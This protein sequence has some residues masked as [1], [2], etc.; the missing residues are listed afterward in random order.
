MED[1]SR[2]GR[3]VQFRVLGPLEVDAGDGP[4]PLGGPKQRA[5]LAN[6][7]VRANQVV[8][9][10]TL[11]DALW[12]DDSPDKARNT[13]QT[14]VSNL[15]RPLGDSRLQG[16]PPGYVLHLDPIEL[17]ADRFDSLVREA[18]KT[19]PVDPMVAAS[20]LEDALGMWRGP[21][22][23]DLA[24]QPSLLAESARLD[25]L[26]L[27]AQQARC[28]ALLACGDPAR[29][30]GILEALVAEHPL[31]ESLWVLLLLS[32]YRDG[33]Q[34]E[35][36]DAFGR[37]RDLLADE[38]GID[39]SPELARLHE[40]ILRQDPG[41]LP[42]GEPLRGYRLMEK[43][44]EGPTAGVFRG[45]HPQEGRDVAVKVVRE[46][47]ADDPEF[48]RTF[49]A[50]AQIVAS[51]EHPAIVPIHD[52]WREPGRAYV[53]SKYLRGG[54]L[55]SLLD[56][57][58][59][60]EDAW[61][62]SVIERVASAVA[63]AH[64]RGI[65]HGGVHASNILFDTE[66]RAYLAD[67]RLGSNGAGDPSNDDREVAE[68]A[69]VL[70]GDGMPRSIRALVE[71]ANRST[72]PA[73]AAFVE[74]ARGATEPTSAHP[75][76]GARNPYKGLRAFA[77]ADAADFFGRDSLV[78]RLVGA[79]GT[80][81]AG[82]F[83]AI[84][85]PSGSGKS[86]V[87][88][89]G[90]VPAIKRGDRDRYVASMFPGSHPFDE[91]ETAL[92]RVAARPVPRLLETIE[93]GPRGLLEAADLVL[94]PEGELVLVVD[95][96]EE[97]FT[98]TAAGRERE[99]FLEALRVASVD[100][101]SRILVIVTL[102]ADFYDRPLA[103]A[104][105]GDLLAAGTQAIPPLTPDELEQAIRRPAE[106]VGIRTEPGLEAAMIADVTQQ[107]GGLPLV[108]YAL[109]E[110]FERRDDDRLTLAAYEEIG[111]V[112]GALSARAERLYR[113]L[114]PG[115]RD[116]VRQVFLRLVALGEG[117]RDTRRRVERRELHLLDVHE[118]TIDAVLDAY[119]RH[120]LLTFDR[121]PNSRAPTVEIAH[122]AL[123]DA[124]PRLSGWI[125]DAREDLRQDRQIA[126]ASA[127][128]RAAGRDESFLLRGARLEQTESWARGTDLAIGRRE[129]EY[130]KTSADLHASER[131]AEEDR[132]AREA[133][134]DRRGRR[135]L[136]TAV[137][138][139]AIAALI[140][141]SLA[142]VATDQRERAAQAARIASTRELAAASIA[143]LEVDPDLSIL[144]AQAAVD[145]TRT[146]DGT[147]LPEAEEALHRAIAAA[148]IAASFPGGGERVVWGRA[149]FATTGTGGSVLL[150]DPADGSTRRAIHVPA[151]R[152]TDLAFSPDGSA[153]AVTGRNGLLQVTET[154][155]T[156]RWT[157]RRPGPVGGLSISADGSRV[158]A[159][160]TAS[161]TVRVFDLSSG[162]P[163]V[164]FP[165]VGVDT[166]LSHDGGAIAIATSEEALV[167]DIASGHAL[168]PPLAPSHG[169]DRVAWSPDGRFI[170]TTG[171]AAAADVWDA[172]E[173][174]FI[175]TG[176]TH[177]G[178]AGAIA[179]SADPTRLITG[180]EDGYV[181]VWRP[182]AGAS[183]VI[184]V[185]PVG[186]VH[187]VTDLAI[188]P[189]GDQ[190]MVATG[191]GGSLYMV[192]IG[193]D[194][195][196]EWINLPSDDDLD[197]VR[198]ATNTQLIAPSP[199]GSLA[200]WDL[201]T[202]QIV[203]TLGRA[204]DQ[205]DF[206]LSP[207]GRLIAIASGVPGNEVPIT[208]VT[209]GEL[210][211]EVPNPSEVDVVDW[212]PDGTQLALAAFGA[213]TRIVDR[214][215]HVTE[216]LA[217]DGYES[218]V[219]RFGPDGNTIATASWSEARETGHVTIW[220]SDGRLLRT[221]ATDASLGLEFDP[222][223]ST[224][225]TITHAGSLTIWNAADWTKI[226]VLGGS[227]AAL[228]VDFSPDGSTIATGNTD[229]TVRLYDVRTGA[230]RL[231]L[232]G[233][234]WWVSSV[235]FSPDGTKLASLSPGDVR[236][237]ALDID[238][239][240]AIAGQELSRDLTDEECRRYLHVDRCTE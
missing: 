233:H 129:R 163:V 160:W 208:S 58:E 157:A 219:A 230:Q 26:R 111:G 118:E 70:L 207:D 236:V 11:I 176:P 2:Y 99:L 146:V 95:Q 29:S 104:R 128:W 76:T 27:D 215:G 65:V 140:S 64:E 45:M 223:G 133:E 92:L 178:T 188:S 81:S 44:G 21:A 43:I 59:P 172:A 182:D 239:L 72:A 71:R 37:A 74:A 189:D 73:A 87:V 132:R 166:A 32:L 144:L 193:I 135:W 156:P 88:R 82:G 31:R 134:V 201:A 12:G 98:L 34:A 181:K 96:L 177:T 240:I 184:S 190:V 14:Y 6:L 48:V 22:L 77:E 232:R 191:S 158:A 57:G 3:R 164:T 180:A 117:T 153:I 120:R 216:V 121:E 143:N 154:D 152:L 93:A 148:R 210:L 127:E 83:L 171:F 138:V 16:R 75:A 18:R 41:L 106:R 50:D 186:D 115:S 199:G 35:A 52:F 145:Q 200:L 20:M 103:Y 33:R 19:L 227:P 13:L 195:D 198:F 197:H 151:G 97:I 226:A 94:P 150:R 220:G 55:R 105:F 205:R 123:L 237:W 89:A 204:T 124:W 206:D 228:D 225:A 91:L 53:V 56:D 67:F 179:W 66:R 217:E 147:V 167:M 126:R 8:P 38:L 23:A 139:F 9:A 119:G 168:F 224:V 161:G 235:A 141:A 194:G 211:S 40:R 60:I 114:D 136:R 4:I 109:T 25:D 10:D 84:V 170:A 173:G 78:A 86:S 36:L 15:R 113:D 24:D 162:A 80:G 212:S 231:V 107:P 183:E 234:R 130:L 101:E 169:V 213:G 196:A 68:L 187:H 63:F 122:E 79:L 202:A 49:E 100:P 222:T 54:S 47:F 90:L 46:P 51:L 175:G 174:R 62:L 30:V 229:G 131:R 69:T 102:R 214:S 110:L 221:I 112:A 155:G 39:P 209:T 192:D 185:P 61:A 42:S 125:D 108:E 1:A 165:G 28:E 7:L 85:G 137:A 149:G 17:D 116:A 238:D 218:Y 5:V 203:G 142:L 159:S